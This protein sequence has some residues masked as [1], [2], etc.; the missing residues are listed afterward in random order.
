M[1][2]K[3]RRSS[4]FPNELLVSLAL[5][6]EAWEVLNAFRSGD[7][8]S[9]EKYFNFLGATI[10]VLLKEN[11][12]YLRELLDLSGAQHAGQVLVGPGLEEELGVKIREPEGV[13]SGLLLASIGRIA[14]GKGAF[15]EILKTN[16]DFQSLEM[17]S[18]A[19]VMA[20]LTLNNKRPDRSQINTVAQELK[21]TFGPT[22]LLR[23]L[24]RLLFLD[25]GEDI[26]LMIDG[27][28]NGAV[29]SDI[30]QSSG[31]LFD[32]AALI[33]ISTGKTGTADI[34]ERFNR[35][36]ARGDNKDS[37]DF[38][39]FERLDAE[40]A[41]GISDALKYAD[42]KIINDEMQHFLDQIDFLMLMYDL[43]RLSE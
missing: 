21:K 24:F 16:Y 18:V 8:P 30:K 9:A 29:A 39:E 6:Q 38:S 1:K 5:F 26:R 4:N 19:V 28:R 3:E 7:K 22:I 40:E 10:H 32:R 37:I 43:N 35:S 31:K 41:D 34:L 36:K 14:S 15:S 27:V 23:T 11:P 2:N 20:S 12:E 33:G 42:H 13:K 17:S 25:H